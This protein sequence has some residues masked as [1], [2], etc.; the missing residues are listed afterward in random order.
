[1]VGKKGHPPKTE[2]PSPEDLLDIIVKM[3]EKLVNCIRGHAGW[4]AFFFTNAHH[5][6]VAIRF[7]EPLAKQ[8]VYFK[9]FK[10]SGLFGHGLFTPYQSEN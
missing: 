4:I 5:D 1:M 2:S 6:I 8:I 9:P 3:Q 10:A 7:R